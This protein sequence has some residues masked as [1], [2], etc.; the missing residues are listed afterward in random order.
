[1]LVKLKTIVH[2]LIY[3]FA[4]IGLFLTA[5]YVAVRLKLTDT[6]GIVID[7]QDKS[8]IKH[9]K[10]AAPYQKFPLAHRPEWIAFKIAVTK[11]KELIKAISKETGVPERVLI[12]LLVPEQMRLF[13]SNRELFK[14]VFDPLKI[15]G[16]Q[17]QFSWGIFGIKDETARMVEN[18]LK[19]TKSPFYLGPSFEKILDF[20]TDNPDEERFSR[21]IDEH[22]HRYAYLYTALYIAQIEAQWKKAGF[23]ISD[24]PD[25]LATLFNLGFA[26]SV[27]K[28]NPKADGSAMEIDGKLWSFGDLAG[29][30]YYSDELIEIFPV[31]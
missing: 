17:S 23:P 31:K 16:S 20:K 10:N 14:Q 26:K 8:F 19:N 4:F 15:L 22:N 25:I 5:G 28:A 9:E 7:E 3:I 2:I 13:N 18:H 24:K 27:P 12:S 1:M 30:F 6:Y 29:V 21:I 11:D